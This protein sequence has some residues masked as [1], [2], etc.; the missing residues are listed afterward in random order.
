MKMVV[1]QLGHLFRNAVD[2]DQILDRGAADRLGGA[3]MQKQ[4]ALAAG[5]DAG[6]LVERALDHLLLAAGAM[7]ADG[8]AM[9]LVAQPLDEIEHRIAHRQRKR[10]LAPDK[11]ALAAGVAVLALGDADRGDA[12]LDAEI[13]ED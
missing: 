2:L 4:R 3:E 10:V 12:V 5:A 7:R 11:E 1:D 13:G 8:E 6:D 9:D